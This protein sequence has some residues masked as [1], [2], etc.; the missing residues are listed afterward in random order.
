[1]RDHTASVRPDY[2]MK[3]AASWMGFAL[4]WDEVVEARK[5]LEAEII[6]DPAFALIVEHLHNARD[7]GEDPTD[8][9]VIRVAM[10]Q[11]RREHS[12][13]SIRWNGYGPLRGLDPDTAVH[14]P[15]VYYA[16][17]GRLIKI[18]TTTNLR[19]RMTSLGVQS[20]VAVE[21]GDSIRE[22]QRHREFKASHSHG[23]W[24]ISDDVLTEHVTIL[25]AE[26][27]RE[28]GEAIDAWIHAR[29]RAGKSPN[30]TARRSE[31]ALAGRRRDPST[32]VLVGTAMAARLAGISKQAFNYWRTS[33]KIAPAGVGPDGR[34]LYRVAEVLAVERAASRVPHQNR[35]N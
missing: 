20:V 18:G 14:P 32:P 22:H 7:A 13:G 12:K 33:G 19:L 5:D 10:E 4:E 8:P 17:M 27:Q 1:M 31:A 30:P 2:T 25:R 3:R 21:P 6:K 16:T 26:F 9:E 15:L 23:E 11:G 24:F 35:K 34:N 29:L 28:T